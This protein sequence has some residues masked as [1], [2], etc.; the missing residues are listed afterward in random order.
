MANTKKGTR[1]T[2]TKKKNNTAIVE[3]MSA[4]EMATAHAGAG[5]QKVGQA[6]MALPFVSILQALSPQCAKKDDAYVEGA[7]PGMF[8]ESVSGA[9]WDG[10]EGM[11]I[12]PCHFSHH[13]VEWIKRDEGGGF[14]AV[15]GPDMQQAEAACQD[16]EKHDLVDTHQQAVMVKLPDGTWTEAIFPLKSTGL[17]PSR[18]WN[19]EIARQRR[20]IDG[21]THSKL[22]RWWSV[23]KA[24]TS[25]RSNDK[26]RFFV[27]KPPKIQVDLFDMGDE[28]GELLMRARGF[29]ELCDAGSANVDWR[30]MEGGIPEAEVDE[31]QPN[32]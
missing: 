2:K 21:E 32:F 15:H 7:E 25:E 1:V 10:D 11:M 28:G 18:L 19:T 13:I 24:T 22:P 4:A 12:I 9:I 16:M 23:W 8:F 31:D 30:K 27:L 3:G 14:V 6:E 29:Q 5:S 20:E 26:G 17:T